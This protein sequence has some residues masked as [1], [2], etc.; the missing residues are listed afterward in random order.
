MGNTAQYG[1]EYIYSSHFREESSKARFYPPVWNSQEVSLVSLRY[2]CLKHT[3]THTQKSNGELFTIHLSN[4][5]I[6]ATL[7]QDQLESRDFSKE[8]FEIEITELPFGITTDMQ[9]SHR[10]H[11][12]WA[13]MAVNWA[14]KIPCSQNVEKRELL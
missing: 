10:C 2:N 5:R 3:E 11:F 13:R 12:T 6:T 8:E 1:G 7:Y 14:T 9:T 4:H